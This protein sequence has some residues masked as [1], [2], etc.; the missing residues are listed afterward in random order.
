MTAEWHREMSFFI[1]FLQEG[2]EERGFI[3]TTEDDDPVIQIRHPRDHFA[4]LSSR[5]RVVT[6]PRPRRT[7]AA[8]TPALHEFEV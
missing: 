6:E 1:L 8:L 2:H 3:L 4:S 7:R 5:I